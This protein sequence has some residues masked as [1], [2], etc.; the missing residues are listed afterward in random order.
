VNGH[1]PVNQKE[2]ESPVKA[3]G[4]LFVIDGGISKA[5]R[6]KTG[7]AGYTLIYDS[8]SLQLAEHKSSDDGVYKTPD[9][10]IVEKLS[11]R[12]NVSDTDQGAEL[13]EKAEDLKKLIKAYRSGEINEK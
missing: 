3:N 7:I 4:R 2:G 6:V 8:H 5:Y 1:V 11:R 10:R 9:I 13:Y 12:F